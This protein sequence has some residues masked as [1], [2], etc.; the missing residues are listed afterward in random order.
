MTG[1]AFARFLVKTAHRNLSPDPAAFVVINPADLPAVVKYLDPWIDENTH[2]GITPQEKGILRLYGDI[3]APAPKG[4]TF[5]THRLCPKGHVFITL[6]RPRL[7]YDSVTVLHGSRMPLAPVWWDWPDLEEIHRQWPYVAP[8]LAA[9]I[10]PRPPQA[11]ILKASERALLAAAIDRPALVHWKSSALKAVVA[12]KYARPVPEM[13]QGWYRTTE[14]GC[15]AL[16]LWKTSWARL[17][18]DD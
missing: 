17:L 8:E 10:Y 4:H 1:R 7:T 18:D 13:G 3:D 15:R 2:Q 12:R 5:C 16:K 9:L 14:L 6:T 11:H